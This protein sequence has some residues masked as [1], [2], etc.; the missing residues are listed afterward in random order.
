M[1]SPSWQGTLTLSTRRM[2]QEGTR[3]VKANSTVRV[4]QVGYALGGNDIEH[5]CAQPGR[6][7]MVPPAWRATAGS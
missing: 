7:G 3:D 1:L 2:S 6:F 4:Q 5:E